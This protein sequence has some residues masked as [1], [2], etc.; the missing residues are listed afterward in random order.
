M[1]AG[2]ETVRD[3]TPRSRSRAT[4]VQRADA[5]RPAG[6]QPEPEGVRWL[7]P[8]DA[9]PRVVDRVAL[10]RRLDE[11]LASDG[12]R[13][14]AAQLTALLIGADVDASPG[15]V[16]ARW[17][18]GVPVRSIDLA[19]RAGLALGD[20]EV[21]LR[22]LLRLGVLR[23]TDGEGSADHACS[24][25]EAHAGF[26]VRVAPEYVHDGPAASVAWPSVAARLAGSAAALLV[27]RALA[28][29]IDRPGRPVVVPYSVLAAAT[30][31]SEGMV[32]RGIAAAIAADVVLSRPSVG[33]A[34][35]Y[36]FTEWALGRG[37][38]PAVAPPP[39]RLAPPAS[40]PETSGVALDARLANPTAPVTGVLRA[41]VAG[42]SVEVPSATGGELT[43]ETVVDGRP[44]TARLTIPPIRS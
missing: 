10:A 8:L 44:V 14:R 26:A 16:S 2:P 6:G 9:A 4:P 17:G 37:D 40:R 33:R 25:T 5:P 18:A 38:E 22:D 32:K 30:R 1:G 12:A 43:V 11:V 42:V 20:V 34:P 15:A 7:R 31:Y 27:T 39:A 19:S 35:T 23:S 41:S 13:W 36:A 24:A 29:C 28:D 21:A 3:L